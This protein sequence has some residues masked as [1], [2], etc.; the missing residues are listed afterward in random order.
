VILLQNGFLSEMQKPWIEY[1]K[2]SKCFRV[3][4]MD[5]VV[6]ILPHTHPKHGLWEKPR[7]QVKEHLAMTDRLI[8]A[9]AVLAE[10]YSKFIND[11]I[12]VP[13]YLEYARWGTIILPEKKHAKKLRVGWAGG[14]E[15]NGDLAFIEPVIKALSKE[16]DWIF[17]GS[18]PET[19]RPYVAEF[20]GGVDFQYYPQNLANLNLDLA[21][22][23]LEHNRFN[24]AKTNLRLL[25][26]GIM[27]WPIVCS[28]IAPY[29][30][31]PVTRVGNNVDY[32][33]REIREKIQ[34]VDALRAEGEVLRQWVLDNY[35]LENHTDE[36]FDALMP[37]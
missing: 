25:E 14:N 8:V 16:V 36:W 1:K 23:P 4:G 27:G 32:W 13:N 33:V 12:I 10:E 34:D 9:N 21:I 24:E 31:A 7:K 26:F 2:V 6:H 22:A 18:C 35:I 20:H 3:A 28:D 15:H 11:I 29:K 37:N 17:M 5:D 30:N 19:M